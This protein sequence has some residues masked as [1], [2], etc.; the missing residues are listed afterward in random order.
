MLDSSAR[1]ARR[2]SPLC[3]LKMFPRWIALEVLSMRIWMDRTSCENIDLPSFLFIL[4]VWNILLRS[5]VCTHFGGWIFF[6]VFVFWLGGA[7]GWQCF[8]IIMFDVV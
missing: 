7:A 1:L 8:M 4:F 5:G 2:G 3:A 6:L